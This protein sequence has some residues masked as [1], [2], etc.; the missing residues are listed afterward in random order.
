MGAS[1]TTKFM[2]LLVLRVLDYVIALAVISAMDFL[3]LLDSLFIS[4]IRFSVN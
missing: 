2:N 1:K 3:T 4:S